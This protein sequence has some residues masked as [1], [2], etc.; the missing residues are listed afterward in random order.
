MFY[1]M[2]TERPPQALLPEIRTVVRQ[3]DSRVAVGEART[4]DEIVGNSLRQQQT[5]AALISAFAVGALIL[6]AMGLFG[7]I[8]G[9]VTRRSHELA[10][11]MA[12]GADQ[13]AV[14]RL[15][16]REGALLVAF[17]VLIGLPGILAAGGLIRAILV[18]VS[19]SDP[20]TLAAVSL[21]LVLVTLAT[22]YVPARRV[23]KIEPA[24]LLVRSDR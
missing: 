17:G 22:C 2:R 7:V 6:A 9:S 8:S 5:S 24:Q 3:I 11:R 12:L 14:L 1:V 10:V 21:G 16:L 15:V 20:L 13:R 18:G 23:L 19:P 4:M